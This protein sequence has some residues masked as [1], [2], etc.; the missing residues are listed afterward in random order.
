[1]FARLGSTQAELAS[2]LSVSTGIVAMWN[3]GQRKPSLGNRKLLLEKFKIPIEAWDEEP[4]QEH[5]Q[6]QKQ[7]SPQWGANTVLKRIETLENIVEDTL[8][9]VDSDSKMTLL[10]QA[11]VMNLLGR[12]L[13]ELRRLKGEEVAEIRVLR[14]PKWIDVKTAIMNALELHPAAL[15]AVIEA[16]E[17]LEKKSA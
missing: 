17:D 4:E 3:S 2:R 1:M 7:A 8:G 13:G 11:K 16:L 5:S 9:R 6:K 14:H 15:D 10:E 12:T